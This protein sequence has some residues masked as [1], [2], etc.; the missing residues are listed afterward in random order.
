MLAIR[1]IFKKVRDVGTGHVQC[2]DLI[3]SGVVIKYAVF[4]RVLNVHSLT[5]AAGRAR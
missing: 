5:S 3:V 2:I 4:P 1:N